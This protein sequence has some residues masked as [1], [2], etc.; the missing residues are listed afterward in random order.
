MKKILLTLLGVI[1]TTNLF[2]AQVIT[3]DDLGAG[4][5][6]STSGTFASTSTFT[7]DINLTYSGY[8]SPGLSYWLE[9]SSAL[10]PALSIA[11]IIYTTFTDSNQTVSSPE[12]FTASSGSSSGFL[13]E[14]HDLGA[15]TTDGSTIAAGTY[16]IAQITFALTNAA[17]GTYTLETTS[18]LPKESIV[19]DSSFNDNSLP[20]SSYTITVVPEPSVGCLATFGA[21]MFAGIRRLRR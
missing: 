3:F 4:G 9:A 20:V 21:L 12:N 2:A 18:V 15:T 5:G 1:A 14:T 17:A 8:A 16:T 11:S 6:T 19:T 13:S 10:A 7:L